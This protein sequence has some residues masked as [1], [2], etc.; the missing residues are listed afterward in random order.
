LKNAVFFLSTGRCGTQFFADKLDRHFGSAALVEHEPMHDGYR[1]LE[2]FR[3]YHYDQDLPLTPQIDEH[4]RG[5]NKR[6]DVRHYVETGWPMYGALPFLIKQLNYKVKL[7]HLYRHPLRVAAS[8]TTHN[9]YSRG[10]WSKQ[11]SIA[12]DVHGVSQPELAGETWAQMSEFEKCIFWWTEINS[13]ALRFH[14]AHPAVPWLT[15]KFEDVFTQE[16]SRELKKLADFIEL[17]HNDQFNN[18]IK[19]KIDGYFGKTTKSINIDSLHKYPKTKSLM[20]QLGYTVDAGM[21]EEIES[22]YLYTSML[23]YKWQAAAM[24]VARGIKRMLNR[25]ARLRG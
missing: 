25:L 17:P 19:A 7:V 22:R 20:L 3:A 14:K 13:F 12:P 1:P 24:S 10:E 4:I 16:G 18:S 9:V 15:L 21:L 8:L 2:Y 11:M 6:S 5:I 23:P